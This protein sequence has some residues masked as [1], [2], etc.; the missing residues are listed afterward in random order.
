MHLK[1]Q[2]LSTH[3][4]YP[5]NRDLN[6]IFESDE[7]RNTSDRHRGVYEA[8]IIHF[9]SFPDYQPNPLGPLLIEHDG[10]AEKMN[11]NRKN[12]QDDVSDSARKMINEKQDLPDILPVTGMI[13]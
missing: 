10:Y 4:S 3:L 9:Y 5:E 8:N 13:K 2:R 12:G 11:I 7:L 1:F 6:I